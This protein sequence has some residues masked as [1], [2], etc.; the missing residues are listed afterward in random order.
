M[1][2]IT[3]PF[4]PPLAE[5][6]EYISGIF[7]RGWLTNNGPLVNEL[8]LKLK[9]YLGVPHL[10]FLTN[11]TLAL[12]MAIKA[13]KLEGEI[14][15]T[16]FSF[17]ATTSAIVWEQC[18]P[19]FADIDPQSLNIDPASIEKMITPKTKAILATHVF[20]NPCDI[21]AIE[22]IAQKHHLKMIYDA[23]HCFGTDYNGKSIFLYGDIS[24]TS[25]HATKLYHT[26]EGGAIFTKDAAL[27]KEM[28]RMRNF[29]YVDYEQFEGVGINAKNS[30][31]HAAMGL[32][33][34]KYVSEIMAKRKEQWL[35]Y[36]G[37]L[38]TLNVQFLVPKNHAEFNYSY[39]PIIF[40]DE[41]ALLKSLKELHLQYVY[42]RRYFYPA[43]NK[44]DYVSYNECPTAESIASRILCL[45]LFHDLRK[46]E[47]QMIARILL[48]VQNN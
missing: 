45:P 46:E 43:L 47:Q 24:I 19:V 5:Y 39:F 25:F 13:L 18:V 31:L 36:S 29:G 11:G 30:E 10:L 23:T 26:T 16:P 4:L 17:V 32:C 14:I 3:K 15:T 22:K 9:E 20:G 2:N 37:L 12:Q 21:E 38:Q 28:A 8:E 35:Y 27:L 40:K 1:I 44:L 42:P 48:R 7:Q 6:Q 34:L 41:A 33:N